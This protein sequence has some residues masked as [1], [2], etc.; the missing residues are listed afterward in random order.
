ML[1]ELNSLE[2]ND[3][4]TLAYRPLNKKIVANRWVYTL[5]E[6]LNGEVTYRTRLVA[7][8]YAQVEG[9]DYDETYSPVTRHD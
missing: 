8:G 7:K 5:K 6:N 9:F 1:I 2:E 4:W 3:T